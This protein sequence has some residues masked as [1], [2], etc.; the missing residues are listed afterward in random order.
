MIVRDAK[1]HDRPANGA[2]AERRRAEKLRSPK[3]RRKTA[4]SVAVS[5]GGVGGY[6]RVSSLAL[7]LGACTVLGLGREGT[8]RR[9]PKSDDLESPS[10]TAESLLCE[11]LALLCV[12]RTCFACPDGFAEL[13]EELMRTVELVRSRQTGVSVVSVTHKVTNIRGGT[14]RFRGL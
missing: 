9:A 7:R 1:F 6:T 10:Q 12:S 4:S 2:K 11:R 14:A 3:Q 5:P 8:P 13:N